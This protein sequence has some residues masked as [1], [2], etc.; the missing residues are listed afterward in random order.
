MLNAGEQALGVQLEVHGNSGP[1][2]P[3]APSAKGLAALAF[4]NDVLHSQTSITGRL[5]A[6]VEASVW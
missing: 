6:V 1:E 2:H 3:H 5:R 4:A